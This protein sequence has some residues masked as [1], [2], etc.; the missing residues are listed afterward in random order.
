MWNAH[1]HIVYLLIILFL[2]SIMIRDYL[3][4]IAHYTYLVN[5]LT[6]M[7]QTCSIYQ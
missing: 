1:K 6:K 3:T 5:I 2:V 7:Q 4:F